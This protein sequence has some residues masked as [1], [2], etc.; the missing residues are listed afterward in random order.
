MNKN[1]KIFKTILI[2]ICILFALVLTLELFFI[3]RDKIN[4][5]SII[6]ANDEKYIFYDRFQKLIKK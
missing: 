6:T 1:L 5:N 4:N 2:N 3:A